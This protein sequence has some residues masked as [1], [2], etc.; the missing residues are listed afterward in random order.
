MRKHPSCI[1]FSKLKKKTKKEKFRVL[2]KK[3]IVY[4]S[5]D[6]EEIEELEQ[7]FISPNNKIILMIDSLIIIST[8][9]NIIYTP[10][11]LSNIQCFCSPII[12]IINY[13]YYFIDLLF[14]IDVLL[15]FFRAYHNFQFQLI[16]N[17]IHIIKH[18][19]ITQ[20]IFDL[21]QAIPFFSY[22][23][24]ICHNKSNDVYICTKFNMKKNHMLLLLC[25]ML[26]QLKIFKIINIKKNSAY[27]KIKIFFSKND[28]TEQLFNFF[29]YIFICFF[30]FYFFILIHIFIG[31]HSYPNW[32]IKSNSQNANIQSL[33]LIYFYYLITTM[34]TV[35]YGDI[36]CGSFNEIIFQIILLSAGIIVYSFI[37]SSIGNYVKNESH[38]SMKFDKD[39][40]ILEEIRISYPNMPFKLY[41]QIFHHLAARKIRQQHCDSNILIN[42]LPYSLK[43]K[44]LLTIYRQTINNFKI[45]RGHQNTDFTLRLLTNFIILFSKKNAFLIHEGQIIDNIIFVKEGR[46]GLEASINIDEPGK[47]VLKYLNKNFIDL[48]ED[49][50]IVSNYD[51]SFSPSKYTKKNYKKYIKKAKNE[52]DTVI[53][54]KSKINIYSSINESKIEKELGKWEFG[55]EVFEEIN[56][57]FINII[58]ISKNESYGSVYM[59][60][61]KPS[62]LSLRVKSKKAELLLLRKNDASDISKRYPNIWAKFFKKSY[63]NM[64]SIKS[65][66]IHKINHYWRNLG[67][68]LFQNKELYQ[69]KIP[70]K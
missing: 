36:V 39:E 15:G 33:Y 4:D 35:G 53:N 40:G 34:T 16:T 65:I 62:P 46:L 67:K 25:C 59:F 24:F 28:W 29:I 43:N 27:Y 50:I 52:I 23:S 26:K 47:S 37:V 6:S 18:Y 7:F 61:S 66:T 68:E 69:K 60:L 13:I 11:Y 5:F 51:T 38:A 22:M 20:F 14:I 10:F 42:S 48:N 45:F 63:L 9:F 44:I 2:T 21:I 70:T 55:G 49:I 17:S 19:L 64:L 3:K 12:N 1:F 56:Y 30:A 31:Q 54:H 41:N 58:N 57:Q 8:I 32:I